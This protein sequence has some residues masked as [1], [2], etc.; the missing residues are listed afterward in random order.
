ME[1]SILARPD[2]RA[3]PHRPAPHL[4]AAAKFQ[5][6]P[7]LMD[8]RNLWVPGFT[9]DVVIAFQSSPVLMDGRNPMCSR[10]DAGPQTSFNPRPS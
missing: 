3:Q 1:V 5:S 9:P 10:H 2:G 8:G 6:S 4:M 7:V